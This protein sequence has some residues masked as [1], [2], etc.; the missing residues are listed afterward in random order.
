MR[1]KFK[2]EW[3]KGTN[4]AFLR[5]VNNVDRYLI[6]M[7]GRGSS[8]SHFVTD[9]V[10]FRMLRH[11]YFRGLLI[12]KVHRTIRGSMFQSLKDR[13]NE[14]NLNKFFTIRE[15]ILEIQCINGNK[16]VAAGL[17]DVT[18]I[19]SVA[20]VSF[21][22]YEEDIISESDF[23]TVTTS[24]RTKKGDILQEVFTV[25]P[26]V[27]GDFND[28]W[29]YKL[30]FK[31]RPNNYSGKIKVK[32]PKLNK[33]SGKMEDQLV[34]MPYTTHHSTHNDNPHLPDQFRA[35]LENLK[36]TN[37]Y[38]YDIYTLGNWGN[39]ITGSQCYKG[40]DRTKHVRK[41]KYKPEIAIHLTFDF[42]VNPYMTAIVWQIEGKNLKQIDEIISKDP[43]NNTPS[44]CK[45]F[46]RR[47]PDHEGGLFIYGDPAGRAEDTRSEKGHNDFTI[48]MKEL[49]KYKPVRRLD[50]KAPSV[51]TRINWINSIF[52]IQEGGLKILIDESCKITIQDYQN[53]K[54]AA[55]GTKF[56]ETATDKTT[57]IRYEI[58]HHVTDANDYFLCK[59]FSDAY[60]KYRTGGI[61]TTYEDLTVRGRNSFADY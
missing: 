11:S 42:N 49:K 33:R 38:Y 41:L 55:D 7:G 23:I 40:F 35:F 28:N 14:L 60:R 47:Y 1:I 9:L 31:D 25:N 22:W 16:V 46:A 59:A 61:E 3:K 36:F 26:E 45:E 57:K 58:Y 13:I 51:T 19:K 12:R 6:L 56:K 4:K 34:L 29:F 50:K 43:D 10:L 18:K 52:A 39:R 27:E 15:S 32:L 24:I 20:D 44:T 17:D 48:I 2:W 37:P 8:K 30:F 53:G 5:L 21:A 54:E